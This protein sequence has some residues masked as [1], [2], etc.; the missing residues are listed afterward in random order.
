MGSLRKRACSLLKS[1]LSENTQLAYESALKNFNLF[2]VKYGLES[3]WPVPLH[4]I[5]SFI[6]YCAEMAYA[7]SSINLYISAISFKHKI[8]QWFDHTQSFL[9]KKLLEGCKRQKNHKDN[10][11]PISYDILK[12]ICRHLPNVC[13]N[14]YESKLFTA[15]YTLA[16]YGL[17][18]VSEVV[19]TKS[20]QTHRALRIDDLTIE[21]G[22]KALRLKIRISKSNQ[23]G[24]P[25]TIRIP[26]SQSR[27]VCC[28]KSIIEFLNIRS[29]ASQVLF[30]HE[31]GQPLTRS[32]FSAILFKALQSANI[33]K[34]RYRSHS[35]RIGRAS[36]LSAQGVPDECI[37]RM[38]RW[39]S[40]AYTTYLRL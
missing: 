21:T 32:Q 37:K 30:C 27:E 31:D 36:E 10:R 4:Q 24:N 23:C 39:A 17:L 34:G 12:E 2:R 22:N 13:R 1:S 14:P 9:V 6:S 25:I 19:V 33:A 7:P 16:Y 15:A 28:V 29:K 38:G 5:V 3:T 26:Q 20:S 18:R 8:N 11:S 35:F 40:S